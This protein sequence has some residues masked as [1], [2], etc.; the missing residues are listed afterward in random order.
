MTSQ[1][2]L[3]ARHVLGATRALIG[4]AGWVAP[5]HAVRF[6]GLPPAP[7]GRFV[8]RLFGARELALA[9]SLLAAP[10]AA[11]VPVAALGVAVDAVDALAGF[12]E[13]ARGTLA[14]RAVVLGPVGALLFV[15]LGVV[16][17]RREAAAV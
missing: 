3:S 17:L 11:L 14:P 13:A 5:E 1:P 12:S 15:A 4:V 8:T 9:G 10:P 2:V 6:F 7:G 16:V